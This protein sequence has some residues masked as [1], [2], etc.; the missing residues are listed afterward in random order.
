ME[1]A[2]RA[3]G[4]DLADLEQARAAVER[5]DRIDA[6]VAN[7]GTTA[8]A[9]ALDLSLEEW[10]RVVDLNLTSVFVL[11]QAAARKMV[12]QGGGAIVLLASMLS[13]TGGFNLVGLRRLEGRRRTTGQGLSNELA[14]RGV[15][16][17]AVAP[18]YVETDM[19]STS[20]TGGEGDRRAH[21]DGPLRPAGRD[22]RRDRVPALRRRTLRDRRRDS[23]RR[24]LQ[25]PLT[26][27][28]RSIRPSSASAIASGVG[29]QPGMRRST[30]DG[31]DRA[32]DLAGRAQ[33][34]A[35]EGAV[36]ERDDASRLGHR[37]VGDE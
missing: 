36:A 25:R 16:V 32:D 11:A 34:P 23:G 8:R 12:D 27:P 30:G 13:F 35:A 26:E 14:G 17:N 28:A 10:Q 15:R 3:T 24:R 6:L 21:P 29:G 9:G 19:T 4:I 33:Q 22:R 18:G 1:T 20:R 37:R 31:L 2:E 5:L 7:A